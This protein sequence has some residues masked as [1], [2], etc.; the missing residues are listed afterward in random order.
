MYNH[1]LIYNQYDHTLTTRTWGRK[2]HID[3]NIINFYFIYK[4]NNKRQ[5]ISSLVK[6]IRKNGVLSTRYSTCIMKKWLDSLKLGL[7][8]I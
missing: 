1:N 7:L 2:G 3:D 8:L 4:I 5:N 6:I